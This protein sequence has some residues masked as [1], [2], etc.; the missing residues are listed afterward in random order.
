MSLNKALQTML[1]RYGRPVRY[2][3]DNRMAVTTALITPC[4]GVPG[5]VQ[6]DA[7]GIPEENRYVFITVFQNRPPAMGTSVY[8]A[9]NE[10]LVEQSGTV[11]A[12][13]ALDYVWALLVLSKEAV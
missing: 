12:G 5:E 3:E 13:G 8:S 11:R 4:D 1:R 7:V 10:Y 2:R 6:A 9:G